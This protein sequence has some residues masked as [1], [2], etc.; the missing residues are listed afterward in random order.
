MTTHHERLEPVGGP[1]LTRPF[2]ALGVLAGMSVILIL[3]RFVVGLGPAT[4]LNDGYAWGAWKVF[5]VI[6]LTALGSG[7]YATALL[8]YALNRGKYHSLARTAILTSVLGYTAGI[9]A[10]AVD[11][12]RPWNF[13]QMALVWNWNLHSVLLEVAICISVYLIFLWLEM[14][15]PFFEKWEQG[16]PGRLKNFVHWATPKMDVAYPFIVA[17]AI[18]LPSMHQ[19]SLGSLFLLAGPRVHDLWQTPIVPGL[20]LLSCW[21]LGYS[22]VVLVSLLSSYAWKRPFETRMLGSL[23]RVMA[24]VIVV[25]VAVRFIDLMV[26][27]KLALAFN[28]DMYSIMFLVE[29]GL[30]LASAVGLLAKN[31]IDSPSYLMRFAMLV[32]LG[33]SLYRLDTGLIAF[34]PGDH[35]SYFPSIIET[36]ITLGFMAMAVMAYLFIVKRYP[37]LPAAVPSAHGGGGSTQH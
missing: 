21:F 19:S 18:T 31:T 30:L 5:N 17:A 7:G 9:I 32:A 4:A 36:I 29:T 33:G 13:Y 15:P 22:C 14:A 2:R 3:W 28:L 37:I 12:G 35:W 23:S 1:I 25:F 34:M 26:R 11:I 24:W 20:F 16:P 10:L 27:G 6:V 8:V